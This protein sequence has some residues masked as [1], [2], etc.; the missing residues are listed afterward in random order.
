MAVKKRKRGRKDYFIAN[1]CD[2]LEINSINGARMV[3]KRGFK[4]SFFDRSNVAIQSSEG[5]F[6]AVSIM[7]EAK[8]ANNYKSIKL[9]R[10]KDRIN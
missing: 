4:Y 2:G 9:N 1:P 6:K 3:S 7:L 10:Y 5:G 8:N